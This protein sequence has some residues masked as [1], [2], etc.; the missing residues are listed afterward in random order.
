MTFHKLL[1]KRP[2][3]YYDTADR[4]HPLVEE[5]Q[6]LF[7]YRELVYQFVARAIKTRYKRS[8]LGVIWTMLN[9]LF[10]MII[11]TLVFSQ[12]FRFQV[13]NYAVYVLGGLVVWSFFSISTSTAMNEMLWSGNLLSRI[14]VPKSVFTVSAVGTGL[15]NL[16]LSLIP[17][18]VIALIEEAPLGWP[19]VAL[20]PA[21]I[22]LSIFALGVGL[23]LSTAAV[24]FADMLPVYEVLLTIWMYATPII[25][26]LD[27]IPAHWQWVFKLN[28]LYYLVE[29]FR[30]PIFTG[31]MP[32][33]DIWL[34]AAGYALVALLAGGILFTSRRER[35]C[36]PDLIEPYEPIRSKPADHFF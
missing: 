33:F 32:G 21:I 24:Y 28:P 11:L 7:G 22:L 29:A 13:P 35:L 18:L 15:V 9:P 30:I 3:V 6:A 16:L 25:Y 8:V 36:L 1:P 2:P 5:I 12:I 20:F 4:P 10:T 34:P 26:P 17:L 19:L 23:L 31:A 14:Y 27:I